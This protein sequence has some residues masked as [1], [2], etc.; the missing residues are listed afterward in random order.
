MNIM[1][2]LLILSTLLC[3]LIAGFVFAFAIVVMP[4]IKT[5]NDH[6]FL[7][8]FKVMDRVIQN[9][10]PVFVLVW[11]GS[12]LALLVS[13]LLSFWQL[14]GIERL[15]VIIACVCYI[16]GVQLS[17]FT[18][19]VPL[20]NQLQKLDL[21]AEKMETQ[22]AALRKH[23]ETRWVFWNGFRTVFATVTTIILMVVLVR[24]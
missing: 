13:T 24:I 9:N 18:I 8:A 15:L 1:T 5:L 22:I 3:G 23:F 11:L 2:I 6:D 17:T 20:N 21:K 16:L 7:K 12:I 19:N 4:G 10:Q 14:E